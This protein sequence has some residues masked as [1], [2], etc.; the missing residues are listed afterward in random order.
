M[1]CEYKREHRRHR[2]K[3][4]WKYFRDALCG[5][6]YAA[7][8]PLPADIVDKIEDVMGLADNETIRRKN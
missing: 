8:G 2:R 7:L 3:C 1:D 5:A 6:I 4:I